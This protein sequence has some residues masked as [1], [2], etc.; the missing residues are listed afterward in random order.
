MY[1][2]I[3][4]LPFL[5][6]WLH[7]LHTLPCLAFTSENCD[8]RD[9]SIVICRNNLIHF[10]S[11]IVSHYVDLPSMYKEALIDGGPVS[12]LYH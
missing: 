1:M 7:T 5:E 6:K 3:F 2:Y 4:S 10:Y 9:H 12:N 8:P 11:D